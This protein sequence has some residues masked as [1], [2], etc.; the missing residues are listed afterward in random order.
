MSGKGTHLTC[1]HC[2]KK[3]YLNEQG[4]MEAIEGNTEFSHI[5]DWYRWQRECVKEELESGTYSME[6]PVD[7]CMMVDT[8]AVYA[9][10]TGTLSHSL[11]GFH[12]QGCDGKLD[13]YHKASL[14][15]SLYSDFFWYEIGDVIC[16]GSTK[17]LY[18][19]FPKTEDDVV[20]KARLAAEE[21]YKIKKREKRPQKVILAQ[22]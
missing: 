11:D 17:V 15:Y 9:V 12:L 5:P 7:I 13:Y 2:G 6:M 16:I 10:G 8:K 4:Y 22:E 21:L 20:A 1:T 3:Y 18:Y 19:C 14:S